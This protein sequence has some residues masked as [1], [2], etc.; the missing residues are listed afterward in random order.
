MRKNSQTGRPSAVAVGRGVESRAQR[1]LQSLGWRLLARNYRTPGRFGAEIDLIFR[2]P[3]GVL[4]FVEVRHRANR[5]FGGPAASITWQKRQR[6]TRAAQYFLGR[7]ESPPPCRF[8][9][10]LSDGR[11]E[12]HRVEA[13]FRVGE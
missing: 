10:V 1:W 5:A 7:Y 13:A 2:D 9:A 4:V 3:Q 12:L 11:G 6:I 8:D